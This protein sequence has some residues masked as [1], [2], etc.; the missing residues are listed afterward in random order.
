MIN[1][2]LLKRLTLNDPEPCPKCGKI[3]YWDEEI[4]RY[5]IT[6]GIIKVRW[7]CRNGNEMTDALMNRDG[8]DYESEWFVFELTRAEPTETGSK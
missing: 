4:D 6:E 8:C 7:C 2:E 1:Q 3:G 5:N